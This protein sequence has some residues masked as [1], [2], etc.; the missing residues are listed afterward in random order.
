M[1]NEKK[2]Q[3]G[4]C[5]PACTKVIRFMTDQE[6]PPSVGISLPPYTGIDGYRHLNLFVRFDQKKADEPPVDL[7]VVFALDARGNMGARRYVNLE[8]NLAGPQS[9]NFVEISGQGSWHGSPH[10]I[11]TYVAR[12]PVMGPFVEVF[13]YNR[14]SIK[15]KVSVW[16]YLVS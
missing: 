9:T 16:G 7:G 3:P 1:A 13:V 12:F 14:A 15:R 10:D 8:E 11:S 4:P 5:N 2:S 6:V